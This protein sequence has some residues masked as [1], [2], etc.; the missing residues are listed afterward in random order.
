M[1][2][3]PPPASKRP[4]SRPAAPNDARRAAQ[5]PRSRI[6]RSPLV[7]DPDRRPSLGE[8][9]TVALF[10]ERRSRKGV[11]GS[12]VEWIVVK[13]PS[14]LVSLC[15][16]AVLF[17]VLS[18]LLLPMH[19]R[20]QIT[21]EL[22]SFE[23]DDLALDSLTFEPTD[24]GEWDVVDPEV[25]TPATERLMEFESLDLMDLAS[26]DAA[27]LMSSDGRGDTPL[28]TGTPGGIAGRG[29]R[30][31]NAIGLGA[32]KGS[33][34]AVDR[35]LKWLAA[36]QNYDGSWTFDLSAS[37]CRGK[38]THSGSGGLA[39]N[40]ATALALLPFLGAG[41]SQ[42]SGRYRNT[43][44]SGLGYLVSRQD[45][46]AA[47]TNRRGRCIRMA[48]LV[49][50]F[51]KR[52]RW[53]TRAAIRH[54]LEVEIANYEKRPKRPSISSFRAST[55]RAAGVTNPGSAAT[56]RSSAGKQWL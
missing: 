27:P 51:V 40:G 29:S 48:W 19:V 42:E 16:H 56:H 21:L 9:N 10:H 5:V 41:H 17:V 46:T 12:L 49:W 36:H 2:P 47:F 7:I 37:R 20:E 53:R 30:R 15:F 39:K 33:E 52:L 6:Q 50:R 32:T 4:L 35:A 28:A 43:V 13:Q 34:E 8:Q 18:L 23:A 31:E 25:A 44:S 45:E 26:V 38:C 22:G 24:A 14:W 55:V 3:T 1:S 11:F 54:R